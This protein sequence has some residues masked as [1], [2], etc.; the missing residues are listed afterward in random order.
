[1]LGCNVIG[2]AAG[3]SGWEPVDWLTTTCPNSGGP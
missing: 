1:M 2:I 3:P